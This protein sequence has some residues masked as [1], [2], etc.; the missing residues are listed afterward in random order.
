MILCVLLLA[1]E[2]F[3]TDVLREDA[4]RIWPASFI[5]MQSFQCHIRP[6]ACLLMS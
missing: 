4:A 3:R 2:A 5:A 6:V 1:V